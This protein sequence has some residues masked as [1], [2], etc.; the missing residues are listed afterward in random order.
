MEIALQAG[1]VLWLLTSAQGIVCQSI[2]S[3]IIK[4]EMAY[5]NWILC[6]GVVRHAI[7]S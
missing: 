3:T 4:F 7:V 2:L 5:V 1:Y 6:S